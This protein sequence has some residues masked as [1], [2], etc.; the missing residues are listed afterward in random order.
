[1]SVGLVIVTH[2]GTGANL[3]A[4]AEFILDEPLTA[5][6]FVPF[7]RS[8][9]DE[10][11]ETARIREAIQA[12]DEASGVLVLTDLIGASPANRVAA[13]LER[14]DAVM[15]TGVNLGMLVCAWANR[16]LKLVALARKAV[17]CG[18]RGVK[19]FQR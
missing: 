9:G 15:V 17:E 5:V 13:Q 4:E 6:Q 1:M 19:I 18:R 8:A 14:Y 11:A 7:E 3:I 12:A 16:D 10:A 2:G